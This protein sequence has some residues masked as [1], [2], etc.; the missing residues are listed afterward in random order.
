MGAIVGGAV[1]GREIFALLGWKRLLRVA[2]PLR[3]EAPLE[4]VAS[5]LQ[6][7]G[8]RA[9]FTARLM[10]GLRVH[11]TQVAGVSRMTRLTFLAGLVPA[12]A[13]YIGAFVGLGAAFGRP[14]L[15]LIHEAEHQVLIAIALI[16]ALVLAF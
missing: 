16:L 8:W 9:V 15:W 10:P 11:T 2:R 1:L 13:V 6:Q 12:A 14:I 7:Q 3:I 5:L 4:R